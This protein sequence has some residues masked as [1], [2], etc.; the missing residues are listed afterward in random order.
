MFA[1]C[2]P[3][4]VNAALT[5]NGD[6]TITDGNGVMWLQSPATTAMTWDEAVA[7]AD[8][9]VFAGYDDRITRNGL[10]LLYWSS[11]P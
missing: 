7:W 8:A 1:F 5:D 3:I 6:G 2:L 11:F 9:L 4:A 10:L